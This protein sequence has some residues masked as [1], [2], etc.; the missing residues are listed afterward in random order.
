MCFS[1]SASFTASALLI[2]LGIYC[3]KTALNKNTA[4]LP[5]ACVPL[6]FGIQQGAEGMVWAGINADHWPAIQSGS[7][8]FLFFSHW[9]WLFWLPWMCRELESNPTVQQIC[10]LCAVAG[11]LYGALLYLPLLI[12]TNGVVPIVIHHSIEYQAEFIGSFIPVA[13]SR[14]LYALIIFIPL[15]ISSHPYIK[16]F[17]RLG[18]LAA[19]ITYLAY[20]Y[21]FV[22]IW[23]FFAACLSFY[24]AYVIIKTDTLHPEPLLKEPIS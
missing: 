6:G 17:G 7:L 22:S 13:F 15:L 8:V 14:L 9:F 5:L 16:I 11:G 2:P 4:Y 12:R 19:L 24:I 23:C 1:A 10:R 3:M 21:A 18:T 20:N